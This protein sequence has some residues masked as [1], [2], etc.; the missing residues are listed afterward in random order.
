MRF[1]FVEQHADSYPVRL[2]CWV[3]DVSA[4]Y[5][6]CGCGRKASGRRRLAGCSLTCGGANRTI[7]RDTMT[8]TIVPATIRPSGILPPAELKAS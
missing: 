8:T 5:Y 2:M 7:K 3:L 4:D 6:V 1:R